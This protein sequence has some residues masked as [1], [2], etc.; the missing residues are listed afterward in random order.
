MFG[1]PR[2]SL[3]LGVLLTALFVAMTEGGSRDLVPVTAR[4]AVELK[5]FLTFQPGQTVFNR[6]FAVRTR[7]RE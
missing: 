5:F 3:I 1:V 6:R 4:I 7:N 2:P